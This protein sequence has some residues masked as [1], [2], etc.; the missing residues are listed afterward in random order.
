MTVE[1]IVDIRN[2]LT[3]VFNEAIKTHGA[4]S[5]YAAAVTFAAAAVHQAE[6]MIADDHARVIVLGRW[7]QHF[8]AY[9]FMLNDEC[10]AQA[11]DPLHDMKPEGMA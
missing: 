11:K 1:A 10:D 8:H 3:Q 7:L 9:L 6:H 2:A 5:T 4:P